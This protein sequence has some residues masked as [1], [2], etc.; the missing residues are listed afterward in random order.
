MNYFDVLL[1]ASLVAMIVL[2]WLALKDVPRIVRVLRKGRRTRGQ[3]IRDHAVPTGKGALCYP[4]FTFQDE[5]G[6]VHEVISR[7]QK[8][9]SF[10][11]Q[12]TEVEVAYDPSAP[13]NSALLVGFRFYRH[14]AI[15]GACTV[16]VASII[17][18]FAY[19]HTR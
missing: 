3:I 11:E 6:I 16:A 8:E 9:N 12:M 15:M 18:M 19:T 14:T 2:A 4:V 13:A 1:Y 7:H 17:A 5:S 10:R